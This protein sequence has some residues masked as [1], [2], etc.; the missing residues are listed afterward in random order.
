MR[1]CKPATWDSHSP[2]ILDQV[3]VG[4]QEAAAPQR[5]KQLLRHLCGDALDAV[6]EETRVQRPGVGSQHH[7][8]HALRKMG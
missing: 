7:K 2:G 4:V 1:E 6:G 3:A 5:V 8:V